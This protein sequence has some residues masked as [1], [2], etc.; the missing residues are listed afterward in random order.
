MEFAVK[1]TF[2]KDKALVVE[3]PQKVRYKVQLVDKNKEITYGKW[4]MVQEG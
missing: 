3:N 2:F 1:T 4:T